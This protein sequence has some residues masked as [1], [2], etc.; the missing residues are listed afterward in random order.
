VIEIAQGGVFADFDQA[1]PRIF[2][3]QGEQFP[4]FR[5]RQTLIVGK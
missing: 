2:E 4:A 1:N 3:Q 5:Q